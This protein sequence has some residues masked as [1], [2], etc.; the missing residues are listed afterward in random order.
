MW[1]HF[2]PST[3]TWVPG[4]TLPA[5]GLCN[6]LLYSIKQI[7][8]LNKK[9]KVKPDRV[10]HTFNPIALDAEAGGCLSSRSI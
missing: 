4:V 3:L 10:A 9:K 8:D 5:M 7:A 1:S 2:S 6:N